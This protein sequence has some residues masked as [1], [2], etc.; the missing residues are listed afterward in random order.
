LSDGVVEARSARGELYGFERTSNISRQ[1][2]NEIAAAAHRFG[3]SDDITVITLDWQS[4][5]AIVV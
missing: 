3:Q 4:R 5:A 1:P 2:A